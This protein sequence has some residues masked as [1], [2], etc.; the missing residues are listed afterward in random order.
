MDIAVENLASTVTKV[1]QRG[2]VDTTGAIPPQV[3]RPPWRRRSRKRKIGDLGVHLIH[4][5][6]SFASGME[7]GHRDGRNRLKLRFVES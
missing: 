3:P 7:C 6:R 4:L 5:V 2:R 1:A